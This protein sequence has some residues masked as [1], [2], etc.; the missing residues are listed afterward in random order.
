MGATSDK[1]FLIRVKADIQ[2]AIRDLKK[3]PKEVDATGKS[4]KKAS[5]NI[6]SMGKGMRNLQ[7]AALAYLSVRTAIN[8]VKQA[9]A[10]NVLNVRIK[11][12]TKDTGDYVDVQRELFRITQQNGAQF[13]VTVSL[14]QGL[15]RSAPELQATNKEILT[16]VNTVEQL[17]VIS[18]ASQAA[19]RAGLLQFSQ[20]LAGGVFRAEEFNSILENLPELANRLAKGMGLT[21]GQLR[22]MVIDGK[23]LSKDVFDALLKQSEEIS[24][25]FQGIPDSVERSTTTLSNSFANMLTQMD[26]ATETTSK[27]AQFLKGVSTSF[28]EIAINLGGSDLDKLNKQLIGTERALKRIKALTDKGFRSADFDQKP[29]F[30]AKLA[31]LKKQIKDQ[32]DLLSSNNE[33]SD[34]FVGP[35]RPTNKDLTQFNISPEEIEKQKQLQKIETARVKSLEKLNDSIKEQGVLYGKTAED[36]AIYRLANLGATDEQIRLAQATFATIRAQ[37][38]IAETTAEGKRVYEE[39]RTEIELLANE[40]DRLNKLYQSGTI[41]LDTYARATFDAEEKFSGIGDKFE[42]I[43]GKGKDTL[44]ELTAATRGWGDE[45]T[46]TLA[47]MVQ[48][49][50]LDFASLADSIISDLLRIAIQQTITTP[51]MASI[52]VLHNGGFAGSGPKRNVNPLA[53]AG[54]QRFHS[55]G[56]PGL[57]SD[58]VPAI[59]QKGELVLSKKQLAGG[60]SGNKS[61]RI[62]LVNKGSTQSKIT[63]ANLTANLEGDILR[64]VIDDIDRGGKVRDRIKTVSAE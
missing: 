50:K 42:E 23:L 7:R 45:F 30:E 58:E 9:D 61:M 14:F 47:D 4:A 32:Q 19:Q 13:A 21:V 16:L 6:D 3:L 48:T 57:R 36:I 1:E 12:A 28:D 37:K 52:G 59:L 26:K 53:F 5:K 10:F 44:A 34:D 20:G 49:G 60:V 64:I 43:E 29:A 11:T 38:Q 55:G 51:F 46:N 24:E 18:G 35:T 39:T 56:F 62:E 25:E 33:G 2:Q 41:D 31:R 22:K 15:A 63:D 8:I 17:G 54:A 40:L 27:L